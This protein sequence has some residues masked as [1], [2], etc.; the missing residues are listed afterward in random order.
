MSSLYLNICSIKCVFD[1]GYTEKVRFSF[2]LIFLFL[3]LLLSPAHADWGEDALAKEAGYICDCSFTEYATHHDNA[4]PMADAYGA[5]NDVRLYQ[6]GPDWVRPGESAIAAI[7]L[8]GAARQLQSEKRDT[9]RDDAVI[10][11]FF[12]VWL[13]KNHQGWNTDAKDPDSGG[14]ARR[15][16]YDSAGHWQ[17]SDSDSTGPTGI[18]VVAMWKYAEYL[19]STGQ[20]AEAKRWQTDAW[21]LS[22]AAGNY[23]HRCYN[24]Q[25]RLVRG[26]ATG[27]DLWVSDSVF[28]A[29]ALRCLD[30]WAKTAHATPSFGYAAL[31]DKISLG[32]DAMR[33]TGPRKNFFKFRRPADGDKP[34]YGAWIDQL[35]FLPYE[36]DALS[37][38]SPFA[39]Q[40]S[41]WWTSVGSGIRMTAQTDDLADWR[42]YGVHWHFYFTPRPENAYLY[43][44]PGLQL[45][46]M[47]WKAGMAQHDPVLLERARRRF[48]WANKANYSGLWLGNGESTEAGVGSGIVDWRD[49][50]DYTHKAED[51]QRFVDTSSYF[52]QVTLMICYNVDTKYVPD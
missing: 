2:V 13:L 7:G 16:Y 19:A 1:A 31:A 35:C 46:Q 24:P 51:W 10:N 22:R 28:A 12:Q 26:S 50:G 37:P 25:Y 43:P 23:L 29:D 49:G 27:Q 3:C 44:G 47:E 42:F 11:R 39:R 34:T 52:I 15:V 5:I 41:D 30:R 45:A 17:R 20:E 40:I 14:M 6:S 33:D 38:Q 8:M 21:P 36:A 9:S 32:I 18:I 4:V 48:E